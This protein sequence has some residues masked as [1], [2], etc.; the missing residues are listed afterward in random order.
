MSMNTAST[1]WALLAVQ[2]LIAGGINI[3][4]D[5]K[6]VYAITDASPKKPKE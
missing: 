6:I 1:H 3:H 4:A 2:V 5:E